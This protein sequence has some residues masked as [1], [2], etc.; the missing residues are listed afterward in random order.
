MAAT[1]YGNQAVVNTDVIPAGHLES[2]NC[3]RTNQYRPLLAVDM[4]A[5]AQVR[6]SPRPAGNIPRVLKESTTWFG[7]PG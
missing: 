6:V 7:T 3:N 1:G 4:C 2:L 5:F